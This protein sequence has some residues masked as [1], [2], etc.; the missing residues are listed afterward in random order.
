MGITGD[1][2][3]L[4][5]VLHIVAAVVGFGAVSLNGLYG[6]QARD[7]RGR[8]GL[9]VA[10]SMYAVTTTWAMWFI[11]AV[12][13]LGILLILMS[14]DLFK[15]SQAWIS[16]SFVVYIAIIG[17]SHAVHLP[18]IRRML[19]LMR[20]LAAGPAGTM[21]GTAVGA[22]GG[23]PP[24]AVELES[25]GKQAAMVGGVLNLLMVGAIAL[26]VFKPGF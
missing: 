13:V 21:S 3:K 12:P 11:Y 26:M 14:D 8:E 4:V 6:L 10:E 7:R 5:K 25:R 9:A 18:N 16:M 2:Y 22:A 19:E 1:A 17:L 15:F 24:Q 23:P 20:E